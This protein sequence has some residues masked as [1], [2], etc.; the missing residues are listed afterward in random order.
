[1]KTHYYV[2]STLASDNIYDAYRVGGGDMPVAI[3]GVLIKGGAGVMGNNLITPRGVMTMVTGEQFARLQNDPVFKLH[4]DNGFLTVEE[5]S[6]PAEA[7]AANL[8]PADPS[9]QLEPGDL[10]LDPESPV[11]ETGPSKAGQ[12][13]KKHK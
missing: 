6:A 1:M 10:E 13:D 3:E 12:R 11:A 7:V 5:H 8:N 2:Y 4:R 9:R